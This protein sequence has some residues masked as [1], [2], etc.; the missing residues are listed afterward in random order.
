MNALLTIL[1]LIGFLIFFVYAYLDISRKRAI[2]QMQ[3]LVDN[4]EF[5][6]INQGGINKDEI[7]QLLTTMKRISAN[8]ESLDIQ[9]L[10]MSKKVAEVEGNLSRDLILVDKAI[11]GLNDDLLKIYN[12][13]NTEADRIIG[14]S[15]LKPDFIFFILPLLF[16]AFFK[17][18]TKTVAK[19]IK[20]Y[21]FLLSNDEAVI[22]SGLR[23]VC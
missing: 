22:Y 9:I 7:F 12:D 18:G 13:F 10:I 4:F 11:N 20:E 19:A 14:M 17:Y 3:R 5:Y 6:L 16:S 21:K 2:F 1:S 8:P 23:S 15:L